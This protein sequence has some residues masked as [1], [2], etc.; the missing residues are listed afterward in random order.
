M[1]SLRLSKR[2]GDFELDIA[3]D[4]PTPGVVALFG[5]SG[6]GKTTVTDLIAGLLAPDA[7]RIEVDGE[8]LFEA[9]RINLPPERRGIGYVFQDPRLFPH[10]SVLGN[11]CYGENRSRARPRAIAMGEI[12]DLLGLQDLLERRP[13]RLSGGERQR[14]ALGRA[15]LSQPRL[16]LLDE[17]L[18]AL[19]RA[20]RQEVLPYLERLRD[21][22]QIP[23]VYV[24]HQFDEVLRLATRVVLLDTGRIAA[25]GDLA[26]VSRD[27]ALR[28]LLG[29]DATGAVVEAEIE[30]ID[31]KRALATVRIGSG[32]IAV[33]AGAERVGR[34]LRL[35]LFARDL[36]VATEE[37]RGLGQPSS[38][39]GTIASLEAESPEALLVEV[40][41][42]SARLLSR[43]GS[44]RARELGLAIGR[45]VWLVVNVASLGGAFPG[46]SS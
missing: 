5:R 26:S 2:R 23:I 22:F 16:L 14:V 3:F 20:R 7:G 41:V 21:R 46:A 27:P 39:V 10:L 33:P 43:V 19:D 44:E 36:I 6:C 38:L 18:A 45:R 34:R 12:V 42:G 9:G 29:T 30:A 15:L 32:R 25:Q 1:L 35:Y 24:S 40:D 4:A 28:A 11:L 13:H 37:P 17:P 31:E 8:V